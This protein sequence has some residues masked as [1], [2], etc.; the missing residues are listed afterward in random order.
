MS[1]PHI[2]TVVTT[3]VKFIPCVAK[4][5]LAFPDISRQTITAGIPVQNLTGK[6]LTQ[7]IQ[8][9]ES[10]ALQSSAFCLWYLH[11]IRSPDDPLQIQK[12]LTLGKGLLD[13][14]SIELEH[15]VGILRI[16]FTHNCTACEKIEKHCITQNLSID[17]KS[18]EHP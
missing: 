9:H 6:T 14:V 2:P 17:M 3:A 10:V 1:Y 8:A 11:K 16:N 5:F 13:S 12:L 7:E 4:N 15:G 18:S